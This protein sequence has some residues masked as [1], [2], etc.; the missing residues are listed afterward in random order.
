MTKTQKMSNIRSLV[1]REM[2][3]VITKILIHTITIS[4][5]K[6]NKPDH[7]K[8]CLGYGATG[9]LNTVLKHCFETTAILESNLEVLL[10]L[11]FLKLNLYFPYDP[12]LWLLD[13][14]PRKRKC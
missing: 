13:I 10:L 2:Q 1:I 9:I 5:V 12:A 11:L 7:I 14:Y 3:V 8:C 4:K 6:T